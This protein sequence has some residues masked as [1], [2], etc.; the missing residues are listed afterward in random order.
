[1]QNNS[2]LTNARQLTKSYTFIWKESPTTSPKDPSK[3]SIKFS[4]TTQK[5]RKNVMLNLLLLCCRSGSR[6][7]S[8]G[9]ADPL[10][11]GP[12][13]DFAK[14]SKK[15]HE[16]EKMLVRIGARA[17]STNILF[18]N[19]FIGYPFQAMWKVNTLQVPCKRPET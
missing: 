15:P 11:R 4:K 3:V 2:R 19:K 6:V 7:L 13:M 16:I 12:A 10:G 1:M 8:R 5:S 9:S 14:C 17:R 18:V